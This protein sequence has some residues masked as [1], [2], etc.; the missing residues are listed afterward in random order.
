MQRRGFMTSLAAGGALAL[1][2]KE[3]AA[4]QYKHPGKATPD[5]G[6]W[7]PNALRRVNEIIAEFGRGGRRHRASKRPY[8]VFDWDNTSIM[9]DTEE[10]LLMYQINNLAFKLTPDEFATIVKQGVPPGPFAADY[11]NADGQVVTLEAITSDLVDDYKEIHQQYKGMAGQQS[12]E[13]VQASDVFVDFRAK[14]YFLYEAIN[15]THGPNIGYP[16]VIYFFANL[17]VKE[18]SAMAEASNDLGLGD[19][20][21][22][23]K[24]VSPSSRAGQAGVISTAHSHGLRLTPEISN[25]MHVLEANDIDVYVSTASLED[26]VRVFATLPKYGYALK[27]EQVLGLRL[28][29]TADGVFKNAYKA[30][31]PLNW[32]PGK[33]EV[34]KRELVAKKGYGPLMVLGDSDGDYD[35]LRDFPDTQLSVIVNRLKKGKIGTLCAQAAETLGRPGARFV[36]QGRDE[37]TGQWIPEE[38]T[39]KLGKTEKKLLA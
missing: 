18:V 9:H 35:M 27:P 20:I 21:R 15:D 29:T 16:W 30:G 7:A 19:G 39:L 1:L 14:L 24:Y 23:V 13:A 2:G 10:A 8:V 4:G 3:A 17:S 11:K 12:L 25:L 26:V 36:L 5:A 37:R 31:W 38:M 28:E 22:K 6:K 34:I 33:S 32:G